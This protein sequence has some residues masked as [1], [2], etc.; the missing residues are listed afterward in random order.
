MDVSAM[1]SDPWAHTL[2][3]LSRLACAPG[4]TPRAART[5][6]TALPRLA[7]AP[8]ALSAVG[9]PSARCSVAVRIV[10]RP[11]PMTVSII[12]MDPTACRYG[13]QIWRCTKARRNGVC[14]LS[15]ESIRRGDEIYRPFG[16]RPAPANAESMML[17]TRV[18]LAPINELLAA[19]AI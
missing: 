12:W 13:E 11:T 9:A 17:A 19:V 10:E 15:G 14:V 2:S 1:Q 8:H 4:E 3:V 16:R 6:K 5:R 7:A 18:R